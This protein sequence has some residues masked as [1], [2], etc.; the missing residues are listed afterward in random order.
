[1]WYYVLTDESTGNPLVHYRDYLRN[2]LMLISDYITAQHLWSCCMH[3]WN[4]GNWCNGVCVRGGGTNF[5]YNTVYLTA[6]TPARLKMQRCWFLFKCLASSY[7]Q[8]Q[9]KGTVWTG[10]RV[11]LIGKTTKS[12]IYRHGCVLNNRTRVNGR[13]IW[14]IWTLQC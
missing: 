1:M 6:H 3:A 8:G 11:I 2:K 14:N 7:W 12:C 5:K 4:L 10:D 9:S 13:M